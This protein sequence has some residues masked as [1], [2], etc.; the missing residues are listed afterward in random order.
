MS[1]N[2][3]YGFT[4][5]DFA[6]LIFLVFIFSIVIVPKS[7]NYFKDN[8]KKDFLNKTNRIVKKVLQEHNNKKMIY[9][10]E[11]KK[12]TSVNKL[13]YK[14]F[15]PETGTIIINKEGKVALSFY[16]DK[17]CAE[18]DYYEDEIKV[19]EKEKKD[20]LLP[21]TDDSGAMA[22][23]LKKEMIPVVFDGT[24]WVKADISKEWYNY[25]TKKWANVVL[26][27]ELLRDF[28]QR[29]EPGTKVEEVDILAHFVWIP[30][31]KY[32]LFNVNSLST[33]VKEISIKFETIYDSKSNGNN[34]DE[35][36]THPAFT[37]GS[38]ELNGIWVGK[39]ETTGTRSK[40]T[41]KPNMKALSSQNIGLQFSIAKIFNNKTY[42]LVKSDDAH[43]MKN[44]EWGAV[45]YLT[46][47]KYGKNKEVW[48]NPSKDFITGCAGDTV[49]SPLMPDCPNSYTSKKGQEAST[50]GNVY[51]IYDMSGGTAE[52]VMGGLYNSSQTNL[53]LSLA[54]FGEV[55]IDDPNISKYIDKYDYGI[56]S[57][58]QTAYN[59]RMLGDATGETRGWNQ[60]Q[61]NFIMD[62]PIWNDYGNFWFIRGGYYNDKE[63]AGIFAFSHQDGSAY[64]Y[65]GFRV[66]L[67]GKK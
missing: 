38:D 22:P 15:K 64:K 30:R 6:A 13:N 9:T 63:K 14:G 43:M 24:N 2:N 66:V 20:C 40:P 7:I 45:T 35:W 21:Y 37:F 48:V 33:N 52:Y 17:Y 25:D 61:A 23:V 4:F 51:G 53:K 28:Y 10:Y 62:D 26:I 46:N 12:E 34:N 31:Y 54:T 36:L 50:T 65:N 16:E 19:T 11:D 59:R 49:S 39:F 56:S 47:S 27:T 5:I 44:I 1:Q 18:K 41:I 32:K 3:N 8:Q 55:V 60:N 58:N 29:S 42:G 57:Q 67:P